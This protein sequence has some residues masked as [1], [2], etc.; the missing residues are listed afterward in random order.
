MSSA[1]WAQKTETRDL[2][3]FDEIAF[4]TDGTVYLKQGNTQKVEL[5]GDREDLEEIRTEVRGGRLIIKNRSNGWFN[6]KN[7][8]R[9]EIYITMKEL[10]GVSVSGS[11]RV[12]GESKFTTKFLDLDVSGSGKMELQ[13]DAR[14]V[15]ISV[16]GS[17]RVTLEGKGEVSDISISGSGKIDAE[18]FVADDHKI[19]I[20]GSGSCYIH[21]EESIDARISGS[22]SVHYKGGAR[23]V[24]SHSSGSGKLRRI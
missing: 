4:A 13:A 8:N 16:S 10:N 2:D 12:Y 22:G 5:K 23:K 3:T 11:G 14:E 21:A 20:S 15:D 24:N 7:N 9:I 19:R 17:G 18:D 6:W 1:V